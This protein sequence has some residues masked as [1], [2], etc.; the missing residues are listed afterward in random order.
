MLEDRI[1]GH[2]LNVAVENFFLCTKIENRDLVQRCTDIEAPS[3]SAKIFV[4]PPV[5]RLEYLA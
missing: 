3:A 2:L 5:W 1:F 4:G